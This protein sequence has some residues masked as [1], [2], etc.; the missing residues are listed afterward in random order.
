MLRETNEVEV[1]FTPSTTLAVKRKLSVNIKSFTVDK[2]I[3]KSNLIKKSQVFYSVQ[4]KCLT[5]F[6]FF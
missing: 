2:S 5:L 6:E 4:L 1:I 3:N